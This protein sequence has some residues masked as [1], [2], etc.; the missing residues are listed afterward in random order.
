[1]R[2]LWAWA[3]ARHAGRDGGRLP[4]GTVLGAPG[5]HTTVARPGSLRFYPPFLER[6]PTKRRRVGYCESAGYRTPLHDS[7]YVQEL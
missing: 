3:R 4:T 1:M 7:V 6:R 2:L 5:S